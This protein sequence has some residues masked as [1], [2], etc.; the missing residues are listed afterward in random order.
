MARGGVYNF[1]NQNT[2]FYTLLAKSIDA[3]REDGGDD[4]F[5]G[6]GGPGEGGWGERGGRRRRRKRLA[7]LEKTPDNT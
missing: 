6:E 7:Y 3:G 2:I 5:V 4:N 1:F